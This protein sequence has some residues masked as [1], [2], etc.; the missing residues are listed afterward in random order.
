MTVICSVVLRVR[1]CRAAGV[2]DACNVVNAA[3]E[4]V[5]TFDASWRLVVVAVVVAAVV[6][7]SR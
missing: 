6:F 3:V 2:A 7:Y 5:A 1:H 4:V